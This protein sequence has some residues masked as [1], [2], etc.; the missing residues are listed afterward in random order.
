MNTLLFFFS[1]LVRI[2]VTG[3]TNKFYASPAVL[4]SGVCQRRRVHLDQYSVLFEKRARC[5]TDEQNV[6]I[7]FAYITYVYVISFKG[8]ACWNEGTKYNSLLG[9]RKN[10]ETSLI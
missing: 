9:G 3:A 6:Q 1:D 10:N 5:R 8:I 7:K 4:T 2:L